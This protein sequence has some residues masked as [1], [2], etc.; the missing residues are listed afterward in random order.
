M[1][2]KDSVIG[3]GVH[4]L[5][6]DDYH[7]DPCE[8]PSLSSSIAH[9]LVTQTPLHAWSAHPRLNP[10]FERQERKHFDIGRAAHTLLLED[11]YADAALVVVDAKDWRT[12]AAQ[13][14]RDEAYTFGKTPVLAHD[15]D[16]LKALVKSA[17]AQLADHEATPPLF[18]LGRAERALVWDEDGVWCRARLDWLRDDRTAIDDLKTTA[19]SASPEAYARNLFSVGGDVQAAF[20]LRGLRKLTGAQAEFR[21]CVVETEP[22]Y[23]LS[24]IAPGPDVLALGDA[25]VERAIR[26]WREC[27]RSGK[28]P[29][30]PTKVCWA[31]LPGYEEARW[32]EREEREEV[33]AA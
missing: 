3:A 10:D 26:V 28:W 30:Y 11:G 23:A 24:V 20:Y 17:L 21:W 8:Q 15:L 12:K 4:G 2:A 25:K 22:P 5:D 14:A 27:M 1:T 6:A 29:A 33:R 13:E 18:E 19:R 16:R 32:L 7:R 31:E 9:R